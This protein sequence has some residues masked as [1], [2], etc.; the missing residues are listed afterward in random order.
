MKKVQLDLADHDL[1][2]ALAGAQ[3][4]NLKLVE[5]RLGVRIGQRGTELTVSGEDA[6]VDFTSPLFNQLQD[7]HEAGHPLYR[8]DVEQVIKVLGHQGG[9]GVKDVMLAPVLS[10]GVGRQIAPRSVAQK[11]YVDLIARNDIV[12]G[13]G[14]AG[15][16]KTYLAMA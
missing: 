2:R 4:E 9:N 1:C 7:M 5:R 8:E 13:V 16:G 15:T 3:N 11:K 6:A 14:P 12:F 10:R